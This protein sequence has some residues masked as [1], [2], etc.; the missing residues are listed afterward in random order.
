MHMCV[1]VQ[2]VCLL[3]ASGPARAGV[4]ACEPAL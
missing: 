2:G 3:Q 1:S 4:C